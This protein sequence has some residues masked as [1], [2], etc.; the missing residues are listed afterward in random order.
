VVPA[1]VRGRPLQRARARLFEH[2]PL[3]VRCQA[4]G[5]VVP[6]TIRDHVV[7]LA[8]GGADL[9]TNVQGLCA[10]C[11]DAKTQLEARRGQCAG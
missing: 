8:E 2:E 1:R 6:A 9:E 5:R 4:A 3:C 10:A 11:H 7:P